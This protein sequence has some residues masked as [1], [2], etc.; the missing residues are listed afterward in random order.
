MNLLDPN[1]FIFRLPLYDSVTIQ[2]DMVSE[3]IYLMNFTDQVEEFSLKL[4]EN[5]S[6][7]VKQLPHSI[8]SNRSIMISYVG[9]REIK[10]QCVRTREDAIVYFKIE[11]ESKIDNQII[12]KVT[13]IGQTPS[14]AD[15]E[16]AKIKE[17]SSVL[18]NDKLNEFSKAI[19]LVT[20]GVGIGSY[21]YLRRIFES[22]I[23]EAHEKIRNRDKW[24][25]DQ[26]QKSRINEKIEMLQE[27]LPDFLVD[28]R[29]I[30]GILSKGIHSLTEEECL[31]N[32]EIVKDV[33]ELI[34]DEKLEQVKKAKKI[35]GAQNRLQELTKKL[36]S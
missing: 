5:T 21:V 35:A 18:N 34:L 36:N 2:P 23:E 19:G 16:I 26:F 29:A 20:H 22:L 3:F 32:F 7:K 13:K 17:Y 28:N 10:L 31:E 14:I 33:I 30:Y 15:I 27:F 24:N 1:Y 9:L 4:K 25:E 6:Y 11:E 12:Y 8:H